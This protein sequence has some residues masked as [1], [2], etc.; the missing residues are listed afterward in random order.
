MLLGRGG[1]KGQFDVSFPPIGDLDI[2][3]AHGDQFIHGSDAV[4]LD[5]AA[6]DG[7]VLDAEPQKARFVE[8]MD[9]DLN[10]ARASAV[11]FDLAHEI[12]RA[13]GDGRDVTSAQATLREMAGVLGLTLRESEPVDGTDVAP[14]VEMLIEA[15]A[16]LRAAKKYEAADAI[17]DK[18]ADLGFSLEDT[19]AGTE[20]R[21][22]AR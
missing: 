5:G 21:R 12:N 22:R 19:A 16:E 7:P 13:S 10:T 2:K 9:E 8:A 20:W 18:L 1:V 4:G 3:A 17:R 14:L 6:G 11:L 15:R